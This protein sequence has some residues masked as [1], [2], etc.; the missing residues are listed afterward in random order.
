MIS[1]IREYFLLS[2]A[3]ATA[4]L[5]PEDARVALHGKLALGRQRSEAADALWSNGHVA[6]GL[7]LAG[8][9][10]EATLEAITPF[11]DAVHPT[12]ARAKAALAVAETVLADDSPGEATGQDGEPTADASSAEDEDPNEADADEEATPEP[13]AMPEPDALATGEGRGSSAGAQL[14]GTREDL[15][16]LLRRLGISEGKAREVV[17]A[18]HALRD[19]RMPLLD[20]DV[21]AVDGELFQSLMAARR[22]V[23]RVIAPASRT[24]KQLGWTGASRIS[25]TLLLTAA[26]VVG[27][28]LLLR[29]ETGIV[30]TAS[31]QYN[32]EFPGSNAV[33]G[34]ESSEWLLPDNTAGSLDI[35]VMPPQHIGNLRIKNSHNRHYNDRATREYTLELFVNGRVARTI[36]GE[37]ERFD[38]SP[39]WVEH[40]VGLDDVER[41]RI[42][43]RSWHRTGA[44][45]A[46]VEID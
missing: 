10:F 19:K 39:D 12:G 46:E 14:A 32:A 33:D 36:E 28:W 13:E 41:V 6:E 5:V 16:A 22:H 23:D 21:S 27:L 2:E 40:A 37:F 42:N 30:A 3:R 18:D 35:S 25:F 44:G 15:A 8:E 24:P 17:A 31:V 26:C 4:K 45:L 38:P 11:E 29:P 20:E 34:N 9:A 7:R 1:S 43:V